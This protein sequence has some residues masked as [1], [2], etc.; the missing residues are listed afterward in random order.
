M[1]IGNDKLLHFFACLVAEVLFSLIVPVW[2]PWQRWLFVVVIIG[3]GKELYDM[4]HPDEHDAEWQDL[5]AD[6]VGALVG[7]LVILILKG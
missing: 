1:K 2:A 7:E 4:Q 3:G 5:A 6:A